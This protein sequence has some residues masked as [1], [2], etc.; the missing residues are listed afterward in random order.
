MGRQITRAGKRDGESDRVSNASATSKWLNGPRCSAKRNISRLHPL[1][2]FLVARVYFN[3][4]T[5]QPTPECPWRVLPFD[6]CPPT[7]CRYTTFPTPNS[8]QSS[9]PSFNPTE[10]RTVLIF[11]LQKWK[12]RSSFWPEI[13]ILLA[14]LL[15]VYNLGH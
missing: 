11:C 5:Y 6:T 8:H 13:K 4:F 1:L 9:H 15:P 7:G 2:L 10:K 12:L 14:E 3:W